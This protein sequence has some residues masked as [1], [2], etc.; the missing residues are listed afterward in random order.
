L[1]KGRVLGTIGK[2]VLRR[3]FENTVKAIEVGNDA[4][5]KARAS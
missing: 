2:R 5:T 4:A 3:A 1:I